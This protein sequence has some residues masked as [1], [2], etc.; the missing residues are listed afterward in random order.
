M[1]ERSFGAPPGHDCKGA[2]QDAC[3][4]AFKGT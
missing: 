4:G 2:G 3:E 1:I